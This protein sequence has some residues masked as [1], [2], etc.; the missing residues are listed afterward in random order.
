MY[1]LMVLIIN[2]WFRTTTTE[3]HHS[4]HTNKQID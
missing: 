1:E 2:A 3:L 4:L